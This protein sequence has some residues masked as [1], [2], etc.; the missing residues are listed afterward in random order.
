VE[1][2]KLER[3]LGSDVSSQSSGSGHQSKAARR[4]AVS[5]SPLGR[6]FRRLF[7]PATSTSTAAAPAFPQTGILKILNLQGLAANLSGI[8][9]IFIHF[10]PREL[11]S[12]GF[13]QLIESACASGY[14]VIVASNARPSKVAEVLSLGELAYLQRA[15][16]GYDFGA[17][18]DV[19]TC[20]SN[21]GLMDQNRYLVLNSSM[22]N[23]ASAGFGSDQVLDHL[24]SPPSN[25]DLL[26]VTSSYEEV[27]YH[28][29]SYF[30][31]L[32]GSLFEHD[33][34]ARWLDS[35]WQGIDSTR[36]TARDYAIQKGE[37]R[38]TPWALRHGFGVEAVFDRFHIPTTEYYHQVNEISDK[39]VALLGPYVKSTPL[40]SKPEG[41]SILDTFRSECLPR[42]GLQYNPSQAWWP[43]ML[44]ANFYFIKRELL[45]NS[46]I[47]GNS[48]LTIQSLLFPV[49]EVLGVS[50]PP[51]SD[52]RYLPQLIHASR[53]P[54]K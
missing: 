50:L 49:L 39:L 36:L 9:V 42:L 5:S 20:L 6:N 4:P 19:R 12:P 45:E 46:F 43:L 15:N 34:L 26:G 23:V 27:G 18:R 17:L 7:G 21:H 1:C 37:L 41:I 31:S 32:S 24:V 11:F 47:Q 13:R 30:Y 10:H 25:I 33:K 53:L 22:L 48:A 8:T 52:L 2:C 54:A 44:L 14:R 16:I 40:P 29:Q 3:P 28:I 38:F 51:W 35:Y